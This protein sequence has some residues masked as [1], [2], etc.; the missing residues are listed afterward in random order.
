MGLISGVTKG[1]IAKQMERSREYG[2]DQGDIGRP[3][4]LSRIRREEIFDLI[5]D[6]YEK[7][8]PIAD[9][10]EV[11]PRFAVSR[12]DLLSRLTTSHSQCQTRKKKRF[13]G[14][15]F[16]AAFLGDFSEDDNGT[17]SPRPRRQ[18]RPLEF[19]KY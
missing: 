9:T 15:G 11:L 2:G 7:G 14:M 18:G 5:M 3:P 10:F 8:T 4:L 16:A 13:P 17:V 12:E 6:N 19:R 1:T